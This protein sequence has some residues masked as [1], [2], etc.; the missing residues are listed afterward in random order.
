[1]PVPFFGNKAHHS[2][3]ITFRV[4]GSTVFFDELIVFV[5][6]HRTAISDVDFIALAHHNGFPFP[7][8]TVHR[9]N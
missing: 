2:Q 5:Y 9:I 3:E 8:R 1:M 6:R 4:V 7:E